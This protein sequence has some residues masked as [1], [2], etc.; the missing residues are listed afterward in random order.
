VSGRR[1][2]RTF[3]WPASA[4]VAVALLVPAGAAGSTA[5][6]ATTETATNGTVTA[7]LS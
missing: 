3:A 1:R 5:G 7:E 4:A 2:L 6:A